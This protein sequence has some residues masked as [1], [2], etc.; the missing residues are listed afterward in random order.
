VEG[1]WREG[2]GREEGGGRRGRRTHRRNKRVIQHRHKI[3]S[4]V[5]ARGKLKID[6][7]VKR[8]SDDGHGEIFS[9]NGDYD[10]FRISEKSELGV[11]NKVEGTF[12]P[13]EARGD[14]KKKIGVFL[15]PFPSFFFSSP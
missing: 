3:R 6:I 9:R 2:G 14:Q 8:E 13:E 1:R 15:F 10:S 11:G 5:G 7:F 4:P 12:I